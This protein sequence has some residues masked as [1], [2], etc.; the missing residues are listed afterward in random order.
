MKKWRIEFTSGFEKGPMTFWVHGD[1]ARPQ[2]RVEPPKA[3]PGRGY[4]RYFV[5][6]D[7]VEFEFASLDEVRVCTAVLGQ[8]V[9]PTTTSL[10]AHSSVGPNG[11]WLSRLPAR[12]K[13]WRYRRRATAYLEGIMSELDAHDAT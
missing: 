9:L 5:E 8:R 13:P 7:G 10:S 6:F 4:A 3:V 11:H 1:G 2:D 12:A